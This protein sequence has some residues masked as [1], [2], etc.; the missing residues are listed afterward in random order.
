MGLMR[1]DISKGVAAVNTIRQME[2]TLEAREK[3]RRMVEESPIS[4]LDIKVPLFEFRNV[5]FS[6]PTRPG[7]QVLKDFSL[8]VGF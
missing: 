4:D 6:Y 7:H 8:T 3:M 1:T 2:R 5:D